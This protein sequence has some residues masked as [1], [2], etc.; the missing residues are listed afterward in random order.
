LINQ[1]GE[2]ET[3]NNLV[4]PNLSPKQKWATR[5]NSNPYT[6]RLDII[7]ITPFREKWIP[8]YP[9]ISTYNITPICKGIH[10][11]LCRTIL[12]LAPLLTNQKSR[13]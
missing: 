9:L 4:G 12:A 2:A 8:K 5:A 13:M 3:K 11:D 6:K 10:I 1:K 7:F